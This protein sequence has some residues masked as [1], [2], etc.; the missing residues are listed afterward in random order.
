MR[1]LLEELHSPISLLAEAR[2]R[3]AEI[4]TPD[5]EVT[6]ATG[7][8]RTVSNWNGD[9][10]DD[11]QAADSSKAISVTAQ[12]YNAKCDGV[13]DDQTAIQA[14]FN[15]AQRSGKAVQFP[16]GIC[17][18]STIT[19]MGQPFFGAG[20]NVTIIK[21]RPGL[22]VIA[23]PDSKVAL[24]YGA[25]IH[26]LTIQVDNTV[27][28]ASSA[29]GGNNTFPNRIFGTA[30]GTTPIPAGAG[31]PPAPG[32]LVFN[33][34]VTGS[35][36]GAIT[37]SQT[38][39]TLSC[40]AFQS[41]ASYYFVGGAVTVVGAGPAGG[42]LTTT[43]ASIINATHLALSA[44]ASTT[45]T[46]ATVSITANAGVA[47]PW[48]CGN[49]GFAIPAS[50]GAGMASNFNGWIW[51]NIQIQ[52]VNGPNASNYSCGIFIQTAPNALIFQHVDVES[53]YGG[54]I[55][56]PPA[57]NNGSY[58]AWTCDT[59]QYIDTNL[60]FN[61]IP[62][63]WVNGSHR[64]A[65]SLNIY[66][67]LVPYS[68]G[69]FQF[70]VP[71]GTSSQIASATFGRYYDEC[72]TQNS[73]EQARFS[74]IDQIDGGSVLQCSGSGYVNWNGSDGA[75]DAQIG[76]G[77]IQINGNH[78]IFQHQWLRTVTDNGLDNSV[79]SLDA[80]GSS[81]RAF[82]LNR[83]R[84]PVGRI[85]AGFLLANSGATPFASG[86]D[87]L[88]TCPDFNF[89]FNNGSGYSAG[90]TRDDGDF[91]NIVK[92]Y[93][94]ADS[95]YYPTGFNFGP[96]SQGMGP[97]GKALVVG[98]RLPQASIQV[99]VRAR[100]NAACVTG[101]VAQ[102]TTTGGSVLASTTLRFGT[103]WT[104]Q[105]FPLDLS[106][107]SL[108]DNISLSLNPLW[109]GGT[110]TEDIQFIGFIPYA[111]TVP[112][113]GTTP[114]W[115]NNGSA[116]PVNSCVTGPIVNITGATAGMGIVVTPARN[117]GTGLTWSNA[118]ISGGNTVQVQVCNVTASSII[119]STTTYN[120]RVIP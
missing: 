94:H 29:V 13:T 25:R 57:S 28:A 72:W 19:Y 5:A 52:A 66:G 86:A 27:N 80:N 71:L 102:D 44:A 23:T 110:T 104:T 115:N 58:F 7:V 47:P 119:P 89:A 32:P 62:M 93:F 39:L 101:V 14:A 91:G 109:S 88:L 105:I 8:T 92:N 114:S 90:C 2:P 59:C 96:S 68:M 10:A 73:G 116:I 26:D 95:R 22:D 34:S 35:C 40:G 37:A 50:S 24:D 75:V 17:L 108:G 113:S 106:A 64:T 117:P 83:P 67:G 74:G 81:Q 30:G 79:E 16:S 46:I 65:P 33:N 31:G 18:T 55:E 36:G 69:L 38:T 98:D 61:I 103:S 76:A 4:D 54:I 78:N 97:V 60:K 6:G 82:Y 87:L 120:V 42:T 21:G 77:G 15:A 112:L 53:L 100:C 48:Y 107:R 56:A 49:A 99:V 70:Q 111:S 45:V 1:E 63:T 9:T 41:I 51:D 118:Y 12:P 84:D 3:G 85:D 43:V 11:S 20:R